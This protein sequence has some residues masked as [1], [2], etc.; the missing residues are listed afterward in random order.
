[1]GLSC[2]ARSKGKASRAMAAAHGLLVRRIICWLRCDLGS[3]RWCGRQFAVGP[4][5]S[6]LKIFLF[7]DWY[8]ALESVDGKA[9]GIEGGGTMR[10]ADSNEDAGFADFEA[11]EAVNDGDPVDGEFFV[12]QLANFFHL[13]EGHWFVGFVLEVQGASPVGFVAN[14]AVEGHDRPILAVADDR[15][16]VDR[17]TTQGKEVVFCSDVRHGQVS[18]PADRREKRDR[19]IFGEW[20]VPGSEFLIS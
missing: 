9:A 10:G 2:G 4:D 20:R 12:D 15:R 7:P 6:I 3:R 19:I 11:A 18:T 17:G 14:K 16:H 8:G 1:S 13:G 5:R